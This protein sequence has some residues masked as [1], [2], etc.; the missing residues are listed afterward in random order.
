M[1]EPTPPRSRFGRTLRKPQIYQSADVGSIRTPVVKRPREVPRTPTPPAELETS[2]TQEDEFRRFRIYRKRPV[3][4]LTNVP[5][6][7]H[8]D[9]VEHQGDEPCP[10]NLASG[11]RL[12]VSLITGLSGLVNLFLN[13]TVALLVQWFYSG[14]NQKSTAD[15]QRLIDEV[16]LH[17][18]FSADDLQGVN[19]ARELKKLDTFEASLDGQGWKRGSVKISVPCPKKKVAES[20]AAE[21]EIE[22][23]LYRDLTSV[24][25]AACEDEGTTDRFH[26]SPFKEMWRPSESA[27]PIRLYGEAYTS[28]EMIDAYEEVQKIPPHPDHPDTEN[29]VVELAAYSDATLLAQF[30]TA[31]LWPVYIFFGNLSKYIRCQPSSHAAHHMAYFPSVSVVHGFSRPFHLIDV[32]RAPGFVP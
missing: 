10:R 9:F 15:V 6:P 18:D 11:L 14:T 19:L 32:T 17:E 28:D 31:F 8:N 5:P 13:T 20:E 24:I 27:S 12:P 22:G 30:G 7:D 3:S 26:V 2:R 25:K 16:I 1:E 29:V 21:F 23:L 4:E